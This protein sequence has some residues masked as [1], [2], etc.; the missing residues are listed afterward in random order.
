[1][2][3]RGSG[4]SDWDFDVAAMAGSLVHEIKNP[5]S[6]IGI[7][8]QLLLE[9]WKDAESTRELRARKRLEIISSEVQRLEG[10]VE[11]FLRFTERHELRREPTNLN[12]LVTDLEEVSAS[13][14]AQSGVTTLLGLDPDFALADVDPSLVRQVVLNL[15][16][17]AIHAMAESGG[18]LILRTRAVTR[19]GTPWC[20]VDVVDTGCGMSERVRERVF[21]LYYSTR[22]DGNGLGLA[23]S[24]RIVDEH[25]GWIEVS[26]EEGK[27]SQFSVYLPVAPAGAGTQDPGAEPSETEAS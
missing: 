25:G 27:G 10:I 18:E 22:R 19:D 20:V 2:D 12:D 1:M 14:A 7:N 6:T 23:T 24:K 26:S 17:N 16:L 3:T 11:S 8:A 15:I 4:S 13:K 21:D 9:E 5:L